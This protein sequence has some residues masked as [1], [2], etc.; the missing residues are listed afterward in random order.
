VAPIKLCQCNPPS[1]PKAQLHPAKSLRELNPS[2][3]YRWS[4]GSSTLIVCSLFV[5]CI[6]AIPFWGGNPRTKQGCE[7]SG[8]YG[9]KFPV[10]FLKAVDGH[11]CAHVN[12]DVFLGR[13]CVNFDMLVA[14]DD[15][16]NQGKACSLNQTSAV[17][18][19]RDQCR[20]PLV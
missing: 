4:F 19:M 9:G 3:K 5:P 15:F 14:A 12:L 2:R 1:K 20:R 8:G 10:F 11:E 13:D 18:V 17:E 6:N 16:S 7:H